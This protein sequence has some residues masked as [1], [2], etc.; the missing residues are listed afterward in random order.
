M[1]SNHYQRSSKGD[2]ISYI[3]SRSSP[4][5]RDFVRGLLPLRSA[6]NVPTLYDHSCSLCP[7][8]FCLTTEKSRFSSSRDKV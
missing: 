1:E 3:R 7:Y 4:R 5:R 2:V 6:C 8:T